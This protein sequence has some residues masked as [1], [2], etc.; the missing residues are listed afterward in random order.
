M[1]AIRK[2]GLKELENELILANSLL[3]VIDQIIDG[4][5]PDDF[6]QSFP[7]VLKIY[8]FITNVR[9]LMEAVQAEPMPS[10]EPAESVWLGRQQIADEL[11]ALVPQN[12]KKV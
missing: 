9:E 12:L 10:G 4:K 2:A 8:D 11:S 7:I 3:N 1:K 5:E 6:S